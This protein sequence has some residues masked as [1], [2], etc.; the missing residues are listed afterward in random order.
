[1]LLILDTDVVAA[2]VMSAAGASLRFG[3]ET[4]RPAEIARKLRAGWI[5]QDANR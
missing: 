1:M 5:H 3:I 4:C 2:G